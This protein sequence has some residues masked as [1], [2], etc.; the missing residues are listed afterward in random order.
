MGVNNQDGILSISDG[1]F[2]RIKTIMYNK[3]GVFLKPSKKPLVV[4]R[5][6]KRLINLELKTFGEY[7]SYLEQ[8][9][10]EELENFINE[11][12]TNETFFFRHSIHFNYLYET[13]LPKVIAGGVSKVNVWSGASSTGEEP[14]SLAICLTEF[15]KDKAGK[16]FNL[17][18]SDINTHVINQAKQGCYGERSLKGVTASLKERYFQP[19][20][21]AVSNGDYVVKDSLKQKVQFKQHNLKQPF[22]QKELDIVFLRNVI[23]YFDQEVKQRVISLIEAN[24]KP[25]GYLFISLSE[26][27]NDIKTSFQLIKAGI[28]QKRSS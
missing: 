15:F 25:D 9:G 17:Y 20:D 16:G 22:A 8:S 14:Y 5:L 26:N 4:A 2:D 27:L 6:R 24:V 19:K 1:D 11:I 28:F 3:T 18:A 7:I 21:P 12:T 10:N 13:V 23:I